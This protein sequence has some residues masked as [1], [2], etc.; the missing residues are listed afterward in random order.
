MKRTFLITCLAMFVVNFAC[1]Q[2]NQRY[3]GDMRLPI[4]LH[5][6]SDFLE[7]FTKLGKG[8]YEYYE[9][10]DGDRVKHGKFVVSFDRGNFKREF[11]GS[12]KDGKKDGVWIIRD[13][14]SGKT[15]YAKHCELSITFKDD[16]F[17]GPCKFIKN[18]AG[19]NKYTITCTFEKGRM[20]GDFQLEHINSWVDENIINSVNGV[21]GA[22]GLPEG[23]WT[24]SQK[25]GI[26]I[27]QKRLYM[28]GGLVAVQEQDFSTGDRYMVYSAFSNL[29]KLP[30]A[31]DVTISTKKDGCISFQEQTA[32]KH[33][34]ELTD[35]C[36]YV[37]SSDIE[38]MLK[39][40]KHPAFGKMWITE[41]I[42]LFPGSMWI[43]EESVF[44]AQRDNWAY[45]YSISD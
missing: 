8:S 23:I 24:I 29:Q 20:I 43:D 33:G 3:E 44:G 32:C 10:G 37:N 15:N 42:D 25:G 27:T 4:D 39:K 40:S 12:Y 38:E 31:T 45:Y 35:H 18:A 28:Y 11:S 7:G 30:N 41:L 16:V 19:G 1:A 2:K 9:N 14:I 36:F 13:I 21:I 6:F 5:E 17:N 26:E 34:F 22:D